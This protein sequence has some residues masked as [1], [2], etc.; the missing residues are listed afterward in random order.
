ME[1]PPI[2]SAAEGAKDLIVL[3]WDILGELI[4]RL[5]VA[6]ITRFVYLQPI[7]ADFFVRVAF[8]FLK[9]TCIPPGFDINYHF[10]F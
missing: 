4:R 10:L 7:G 3:P 1:E 8:R 5:D 9:F 2:P 6:L